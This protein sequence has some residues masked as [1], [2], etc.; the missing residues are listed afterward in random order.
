MTDH[1]PTD[2]DAAAH[3]TEDEREDRTD[4]GTGHTTDEAELAERDRPQEN[5]ATQQ[6]NLR[7]DDD[8]GVGGEQREEA[9]DELHE[10][11]AG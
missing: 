9:L 4:A 10:D 5:L 11:R 6:A 7:A 2:P 8:P 1:R 3:E